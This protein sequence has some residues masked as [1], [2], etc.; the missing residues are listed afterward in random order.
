MFNDF[1]Y[2][3]ISFPSSSVRSRELEIANKLGDKY[4]NILEQTTEQTKRILINI[5][6]TDIDV[7]ALEFII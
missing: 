2:L 6:C 3:I 4:D 1:R 5:T 7:L